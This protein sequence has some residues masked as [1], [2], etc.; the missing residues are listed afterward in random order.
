MQTSPQNP[1][2]RRRGRGFLRLALVVGALYAIA[3]IAMAAFGL[4]VSHGLLTG[5]GALVVYTVPATI[6]DWPRLTFSDIVDVVTGI[7]EAV[8]GF[9]ASILDW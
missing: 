2:R 3:W 8:V 4:G 9:F 6:F 7:W 1:P 5:G